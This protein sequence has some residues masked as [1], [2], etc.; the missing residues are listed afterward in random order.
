LIAA[1]ALLAALAQADKPNIVIIYADDL[2]YG[3]LGCY[4]HPTIRT[5]N[6]DRLA[7][8]GMKFTQFYSAA[9]VCTPS[10]AAL[11]T[12]RFPIRTGMCHD[13]RRVLFQNSAGGLQPSE[14]TL[15]EGLKAKG[16]ATAAVGKW[17]LGHLPKYLPTAQGFDSYLGIPYSNDMDRA[18]GAPGHGVAC[19]EPKIEYF[20]VP[21]LRNEKE[22]E[23]PADQRTITKRYTEE[24][25]RFIRENRDRPFFLYL[26]HTM[27]HVPLF[28]S[29]AFLGKSPRGIYGDALEEL[30]WSVGQVMA[31]I[32]EAGVDGKTLVVFSSDNG[33]WLIFDQFGGSA[34]LLREGKGS[35]W[36]GGMRVPGIFRWPGRIAAGATTQ[37]LGCTMDLFTTALKLAGADVPQ[38]RPID[39]LDLSPVLFATGPGPRTTMV[40]YRDTTVYAVRKG[41]FKAHFTTRSAYGKD[42]PQKHDPPLL[43]HLGHDPGEQRDAARQHPDVVEDLR[44]ELAA[45]EAATKPGE[46]QLEALIPTK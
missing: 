22:V 28:A 24:S 27:V 46:N 9:P 10:R 38:D 37:E 1:V 33:P 23:R 11:L 30:D 35:T 8:E 36:E 20:Q 21:L 34:G 4:G 15:A 44:K 14:I 3:D 5:P 26:A 32:R 16:Y 12:G 13:R 39:G 43:Y 31:A 17:H 45:H 40:Y 19:R 6:L 29:E 18:P 25:V 2:G 41:P 7:A 42:A